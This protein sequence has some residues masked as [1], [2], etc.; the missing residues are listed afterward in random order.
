L[1]A[2]PKKLDATD[3]SYFSATLL[4]PGSEHTYTIV[5]KDTN[6]GFKFYRLKK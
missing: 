5:V 1:T 6:G 4:S 2:S 3:F